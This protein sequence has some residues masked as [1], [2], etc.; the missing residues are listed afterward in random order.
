ME[1][2]RNPHLYRQGMGGRQE[3]KKPQ[4]ERREQ[5]D[6]EPWMTVYHRGAI[7]VPENVKPTTGIGSSQPAVD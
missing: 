2:I 1:H 4:E 7:K 6:E 3:K 5:R